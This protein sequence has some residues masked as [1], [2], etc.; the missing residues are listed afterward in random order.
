MSV[1]INNGD[2][3]FITKVDYSTGGMTGNLEAGDVN[4]DGKIDI[5]LS[6]RG[7][8]VASVFI[9]N[10]DGTFATKVDYSTTSF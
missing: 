10:G 5:V 7:L 9:N 1:F 4:G 6:G 2:G 3:T 8:S